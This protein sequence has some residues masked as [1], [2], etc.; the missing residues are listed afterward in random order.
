LNFRTF[1]LG[2]L[3]A[4]TQPGDQIIGIDADAVVKSI[5]DSLSR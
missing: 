3:P 1:T 4:V 5:R 2:N